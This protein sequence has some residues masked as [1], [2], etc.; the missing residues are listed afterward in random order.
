MV[1][2]LRNFS[3]RIGDG[4]GEPVLDA[5]NGEELMHVQPGV[6]IVLGN[7]AQ[8]SPGTLYISTKR[9]VWLSDLEREKGY[10]VDFLS[11]SLHA[12]SRDPEA[13][14]VPCIYTQIET[15]AGEDED[16]DS[17]SNETL[18]VSK[19]TEMRLIPSDPGQLDDL[20]DIFCECAELNPEP[21][22]EQEEEHNWIF[23]AD[24]MVEDE[25][26]DSEGQLFEDPGNP[27]GHSN[28]D[29]DLSRHYGLNRGQKTCKRI[30]LQQRFVQPEI[31]PIFNDPI[32]E[33]TRRI[34]SGDK[35][36]ALSIDARDQGV[37]QGF[38]LKV[39]GETDGV[40]SLFKLMINA[41]KMPR[42]WQ[43]RQKVDTTEPV[44][45]SNAPALELCAA[46]LNHALVLPLCRHF[47]TWDSF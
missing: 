35:P 25:G 38:F 27:I 6:A 43:E 5:E 46:A 10:A 7:G 28:G 29:H 40:I 13:Y 24:Q 16:S 9:V 22:E 3:E 36:R 44:Y 47:R 23:S 2:G 11:I 39:A 45:S 26:G 31:H 15:E 17:E 41:L 1:S 21:D 14:S 19:I 4:A 30:G 18:D 12:V 20:F 8:E 32:I 42:K 34:L 33:S 37:G